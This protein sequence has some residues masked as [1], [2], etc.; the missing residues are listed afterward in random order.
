MRFA[1]T[2][3]AFAFATPAAAA[4]CRDVITAEAGR[5]VQ[6]AAK[7]LATCARR[8]VDCDADPASAAKLA[9]AA[10]R[11]RSK[12]ADVCCGGDLTCGTPD[13]VALATIGWT[14]GFCPNLD[15]HDCNNLIDSP[16][17][18]ATCLVCLGR[19]AAED[20]IALAAPPSNP[21]LAR[22][23]AA[24]P[25]AVS[26]LAV[27]TSKALAACWAARGAG[28]HAN[29][30][31]VPGDGRAAAALATASARA[32]KVVCRAC[33]GADH[34]CGG[35]DDVSPATLGLP[36]VC[37]AVTVPG[38]AACGG[39]VTTLADLVACADCVASHDVECAD[40]AA[41]PAF[42]PYPGECASPPGTCAPGV[43]CTSAADCPAGYACL[44]NGSGTTRYC[45][46]PTC[47][48][49]G[50]CDG[51]AVCLQYCT[52]AGCAA[53][54]CVCPGFACGAEEVCIDDGGLACR[55]LCTGD[56][57]CPP[58]LGVCVN[59][60]FASGLCIDSH[61]CD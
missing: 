8:H 45:V 12:V 47:A 10:A 50:E 23:T 42:V 16:G 22:C 52:F 44:D 14:T 35:G 54:R 13:D 2:I 57:D 41:V 20:L 34:A 3:L 30:C 31:P 51:G 18:V 53:R 1:L 21:A 7:T 40:H 33:G 11:L 59:S 32:A 27:S 28:A 43:E 60:T 39:P 38:G 26:K 4:T 5:H 6:A 55:Q 25:K 17:D 56:A 24:L 58:P 19:A 49:D 37:P 46:G 29:P 36:S 48:V 15:H 9:S 61:P